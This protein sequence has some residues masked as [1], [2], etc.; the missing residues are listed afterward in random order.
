M[1]IA[2]TILMLILLVPCMGAKPKART[3]AAVKQTQEDRDREAM[4]KSPE[5]DTIRAWLK[6]STHKG[7]F[8]EVLWGSQ[9]INLD[10]ARA[11]DLHKDDK[12]ETFRID[13]RK[14][15]VHHAD[16]YIFL[17]FRTPNKFGVEMNPGRVTDF[18]A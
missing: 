6:A 14:R 11:Y 13:I 16:S 12:N 5:A 10:W 18:P 4:A 17:T 3:P 2:S 8:T 15:E 9:I 1:K 7:K